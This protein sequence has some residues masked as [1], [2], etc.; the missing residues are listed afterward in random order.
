MSLRGPLHVMYEFLGSRCIL[1]ASATL[2]FPLGPR[3]N[4]ETRE[5]QRF[6]FRVKGSRAQGNVTNPKSSKTRKNESPKCPHPVSPNT[7][8]STILNLPPLSIACNSLTPLAFLCLWGC[9]DYGAYQRPI[10]LSMAMIFTTTFPK[11]CKPLSPIPEPSPEPSTGAC[12]KQRCA[13]NL[14][15]WT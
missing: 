2:L 7:K 10:T 9:G 13:N 1:V 6:R 3:T 8:N 14:R 11:P 12:F 4:S 15:I 5:S